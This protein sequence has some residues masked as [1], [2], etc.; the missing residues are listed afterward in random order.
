M[1]VVVVDV[2]VKPEAI[3]EFVEITKE[4]AQ[5]SREEPGIARFDVLVDDK[6]PAHF[7]L[8]EVYRDDAAPLAHKETAHYQ[9]WR[10]RAE[11]LMAKPRSSSRF[12][13]VSPGP[14]GW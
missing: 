4:N 1:L 8:V 11:P 14:S 5:K 10:D 12:R 13:A 2:W 7:S 9:V 3:A 6:D